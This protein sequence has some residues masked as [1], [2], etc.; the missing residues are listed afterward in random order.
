[1]WRAVCSA[2]LRMRAVAPLLLLT[3]CGGGSG[4]VAP[5]SDVPPAST[6]FDAG[7]VSAHAFGAD[8]TVYVAKASTSFFVNK[9]E[10]W[11]Y[12]EDGELVALDADLVAP[13]RSLARGLF[14]RQAQA[15]F[16]A[17]HVVVDELATAYT[18]DVSTGAKKDMTPLWHGDGAARGFATDGAAIIAERNDAIVRIGIDGTSSELPIVVPEGLWRSS[19]FT[20]D[21]DALYAFVDCVRAVGETHFIESCERSG[22]YRAPLAGGTLEKI[23]AAGADGDGER[24]FY[25]HPT[26]RGPRIAFARSE[27]TGDQQARAKVYVAK[28]GEMAARALF[29]TTDAYDLALTGEGVLVCDANRGTFVHDDGTARTFSAQGCFRPAWRDGRAYWI[30]LTTSALHVTPLP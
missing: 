15:L 16:I 28:A 26:V 2:V 29:T 1:V 8:G 3:A 21:G 20:V 13:P 4:D 22:L 24:F 14:T 9:G 25:A 30:D 11:H 12:D 7:P 27:S 23:A 6:V 5:A 19:R 17:D 10:G 18:I